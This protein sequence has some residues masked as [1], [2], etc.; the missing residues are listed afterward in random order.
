M[1]V[2]LRS[3]DG[4]VDDA[5]RRCSV[6]GHGSARSLRSLPTGAVPH[7]DKRVVGL[8]VHRDEDP[9]LTDLED[10]GTSLHTL[11]QALY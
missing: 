1:Q 3:V 7:V 5:R 9:V 4:V 2:L 6:E 11:T 8:P 10:L